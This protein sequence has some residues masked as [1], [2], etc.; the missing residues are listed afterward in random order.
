MTEFN[1]QSESNRRAVGDE[2]IN[3]QCEHHSKGVQALAQEFGRL[4]G[5]YL[6]QVLREPLRDSNRPHPRNEAFRTRP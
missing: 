6:A 2:K 5:R 3:I 4:V 1:G